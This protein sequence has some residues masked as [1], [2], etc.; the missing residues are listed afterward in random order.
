LKRFIL[1]ILIFASL[2]ADEFLIKVPRDITKNVRFYEK[3]IGISIVNAQKDYFI[4][5][6]RKEKLK[7]LRKKNIEFEIISKITPQ[8]KGVYLTYSQIID[9]LNIWSSQ[10]PYISKLDTIGYTVQGRII[11]GIK[12]SDNPEIT[13]KEPRIRLAGSIHGNEKIGCAVMMNLIKYLLTRYS[14]DPNVKSLVDSR[15]IF[16]IP[17]INPDGYV[18]N[19]R[20]NGNGVDLNRDFGFMWDGWGGSSSPFSQ[21]ESKAM[22]KHSEKYPVSLDF[23]YHSS[24]LVG[25]T[26]DTINYPWDYHPH[27]PSDS[28][29]IIILS[30]EY[31]DSSGY[32]ITNGYDWYQVTGSLQDAVL[33]ITGGLS[34][35]IESPYPPDGSSEIDSVCRENRKAIMG[36]ILK[37]GYGAGGTVFDSLTMNPLKARIEILNPERIPVYTDD[38]GFYFKTLEPGNYILRACVNGYLPVEKNITVPI[39][40]WDTF[41]FY[42]KPD[43]SYRYGFRVVYATYAN[44]AETGNATQPYYS[45]GEPDGIFYS[46]GNG[47]E[48]CIDM[49]GAEI[50]DIS[51]ND[52][53]IYEG[54]GTNE[55][56]EVYLSDSE[57]GPWTYIGTGT[58]TDSFDISGTGITIA[59]YVRIV[60]D[61]DN[62]SSGQYA[63]F[64]LDAIQSLSSI[65]GPYLSI[66]NY[67]IIDSNSN[68]I[69]EPGENADLLITLINN[70]DTEAIDIYAKLKSL[71]SYVQVIDS[72]SFYG[73]IFPDSQISNI[74]DS[75]KIKALPSTPEGYTANMILILQGQNYTDTLYF[76]FTIGKRHY[77]VWDPDP[78]HSSGPVID[79][80]LTNL[81]YVGDYDISLNTFDPNLYQA[82]FICVGIYNNNYVINDGSQEAQTIVDF[83]N[84][85]GGRI[86]LEGGDVWYWDPQQGGY[87]FGPLFGISALD[88]GSGDLAPIQGQSG[89]FTQGMYFTSYSGENA[90]IDHIQASGT[91]AFNIFYD[92]DNAYY[93]GVARDA[94]TYKTVGMSFELA[95]LDDA[96]DPSTKTALLDSIMHF[97]GI[98][99]V[100]IKEKTVKTPSEKD[101]FSGIFPNII[102]NK[103]EII[104]TLSETQKVII[105]IKDISGRTLS[106]VIEKT[107]PAG[108]YRIKWSP[109]NFKGR[110][111]GS[112]IYFIR[113]E[114]NKKRLSKK[115]IILR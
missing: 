58:G 19:S 84:N 95:G 26:L 100:G 39:I 69:F 112:G 48:I 56:Y 114:S 111:I 71:S 115:I 44:H 25:S 113:F 81:G 16:I 30:S 88:D 67:T 97:F 87:D 90:W 101:I 47:G 15:E 72:Q 74:N 21:P 8:D 51:G 2:K 93:C 23:N 49:F 32:G 45:L 38:N 12:I 4:A 104:F 20:Y 41:D 107:L 37:A 3:Y 78:N 42:L 52:F 108:K 83:A 85:Y 61:N 43:P 109:L 57:F 50:K 77:F 60:D 40:E 33:G 106:K 28:I 96:T 73:T 91:G 68:N 75:F 7:I 53:V 24:P 103:S 14:S 31:A 99:P 1:I 82:L 9:S 92:T 80:I 89:T 63:G 46:L 64:D 66:M 27:D 11:L 6:A 22:Q 86:Y 18:S 54:S 34:W 98:N 79:Q 94:G 10:Y 76:S 17:L 65:S 35:T 62:S 36:M 13:E 5:V 102:K 110:K 105:E 29:W 59:R 55:S 70:G